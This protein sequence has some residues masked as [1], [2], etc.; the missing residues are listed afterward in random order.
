MFDDHIHIGLHNIIGGHLSKYSSCNV[1]SH[2]TVNSMQL[3]G[4]VSISAFD[5]KGKITDLDYHELLPFLLANEK[6]IKKI[7]YISSSRI[8]DDPDDKYKNYVRNK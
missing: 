2:T 4:V 6:S 1:I 7:L 3:K 8:L 5:P